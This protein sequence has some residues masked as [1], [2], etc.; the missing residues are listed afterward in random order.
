MILL[1]D[2]VFRCLIL[3]VVLFVPFFLLLLLLLLLPPFPQTVNSWKGVDPRF[4]SKTLKVPMG[5]ENVLERVRAGYYP[6]DAPEGVPGSEALLRDIRRVFK[7]YQIW[8]DPDSDIVLRADNIERVLLGGYDRIV[9][10][11]LA[12][13][14]SAPPP[15]YVVQRANVGVFNRGAWEVL[16]YFRVD[17][18]VRVRELRSVRSVRSV[19]ASTTASTAST[20]S[21][22]TTAT[23]HPPLRTLRLPLSCLAAPGMDHA[24]MRCQCLI[25]SLLQN[26]R[27]LPFRVPLNL[28]HFRSVDVLEAIKGKKGELGV[29]L[30]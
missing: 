1:F 7:N 9:H 28:Q 20:A 10:L 6:I 8:Y 12:D 27:S 29:N 17:A 13:D 5:L 18:T 14:Y 24:T 23:N 26:K 22:A 11:H 4:V 25:Q 16:E 30:G 2:F 19:D 21:T 3:F 15:G